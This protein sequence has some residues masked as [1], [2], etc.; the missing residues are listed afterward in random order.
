MSTKNGYN[1]SD[2]IY[3][4]YI[5]I[6]NW[7]NLMKKIIPHFSIPNCHE[8]LEFYKNIFGGEIKNT[9][10]GE[11]LDMFKGQEEKLI[12]AEL[13]INE[14][15]VLYFNDVFQPQQTVGTNVSN[16]LD[17]ESEEEIDRVYAAL[18]T[19]GKI[20][21]PL[22]DTFWGAKHAVVTDKNGLQW[23]LNFTRAMDTMIE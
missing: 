6:T 7:R 20:M 23:D 17:M 8:A 10:T 1:D 14:E 5:E 2:T 16:V 9:Q 21:M 18:S 22:Q 12:H 3:K 19:E 15:C 13:H 4:L 11:G